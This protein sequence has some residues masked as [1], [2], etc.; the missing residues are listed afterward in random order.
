[1]IFILDDFLIFIFVSAYGGAAVASAKSKCT[2]KLRASRRFSRTSQSNLIYSVAVVN[3]EIF[4]REKLNIRPG[5][6]AIT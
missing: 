3:F 6:N 5:I 1:M 2:Q 4:R